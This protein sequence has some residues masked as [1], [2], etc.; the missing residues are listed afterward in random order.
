[1]LRSNSVTFSVDYRDRE[2]VFGYYLNSA[3]HRLKDGQ[4]RLG[5]PS[6][7]AEAARFGSVGEHGIINIDVP[8]TDCWN[9][10]EAVLREC[11]ATL[12]V[13]LGPQ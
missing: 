8:P 11:N 10:A 7:S 3:I 9:I 12:K 5:A 6:R 1:V 4:T 2:W 13:R